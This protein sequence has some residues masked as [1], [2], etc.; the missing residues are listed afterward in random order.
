MPDSSDFSG[1]RMDADCA[2][3]HCVGAIHGSV[4]LAVQ[5]DMLWISVTKEA[6]GED[7]LECFRHALASGHLATKM[8]TLVDLSSFTGNVDWQA[9]DQIRQLAPWGTGKGPRSRVAYVSRDS[10]F[11]FMLKI[12]E[13]LFPMTSHRQFDDQAHALEWLGEQ[14]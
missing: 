7:L 12:V 4:T 9:I 11:R 13:V 2:Y 3:R 6:A 1:I 14:R 10:F 8:P 5:R